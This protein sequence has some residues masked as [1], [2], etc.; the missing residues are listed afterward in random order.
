[1]WALVDTEGDVLEQLEERKDV[2]RHFRTVVVVGWSLN[3]ETLR[4][5]GYYYES[6]PSVHD[7]EQHAD[8]RAWKTYIDRRISRIRG[9]YMPDFEITL[10]RDLNPI[11]SNL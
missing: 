10:G 9:Y 1:M 6:I 7:M 3:F 11:Y 2:L 4:Q 8:H 5:Y